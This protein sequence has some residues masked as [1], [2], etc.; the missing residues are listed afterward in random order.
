MISRIIAYVNQKRIVENTIAIFKFLR[1][2]FGFRP[3]H[4]ALLCILLRLFT[5]IQ[6]ICFDI[7][8]LKKIEGNIYYKFQADDYLFK[9]NRE[10]GSR[11]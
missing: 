11:A 9:V 2:N 4:D 8:S 7:S 3:I 6:K 5:N 10:G 1:M